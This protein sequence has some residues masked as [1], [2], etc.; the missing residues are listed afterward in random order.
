MI[1]FTN[2]FL[3]LENMIKSKHKYYTELVF[4]SVGAQN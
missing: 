4:G 1:L 3:L 2:S